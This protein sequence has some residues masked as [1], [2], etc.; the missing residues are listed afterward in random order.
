MAPLPKVVVVAKNEGGKEIGGSNHYCTIC[1][2]PVSP[3]HPGKSMAPP[4]V[5]LIQ[6][7]DG[8]TSP[9]FLHYSA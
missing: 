4:A 5:P 7:L 2:A 9:F 3:T 1:R 6:S 8:L